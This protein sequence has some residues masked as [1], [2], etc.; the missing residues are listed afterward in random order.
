VAKDGLTSP[1]LFAS[2]ARG[3]VAP[4]YLLYGEEDL[5]VE[6]ALDAILQAALD[7]GDRTFNLD[8]LGAGETDGRDIA[9]RASSFPMAGGRRVVVVRDADKLSVHDCELL[10]AYVGEPSPSTCLILVAAKPDLRKKPFAT[11]KRSGGALECKRLYEDKI[12]SW[13][14]GAVRKGGCRIEPEAAK[15]LAAYVGTSLRE[16]RSE[17]DKLY[18]Y[19]GNRKEITAGDVSALVG[20]SKEYS[21]FELQKVVG[22]RETARA[23]RILEEILGAGGGPPL[24]IATMTNYSLT[25][26]KLHDLQRR[27]VAQ[28]DQAAQARVHPFFIQEY[29]EALGFQ[30]PAACERALLLL[31]DADEQSKSGT[32]DARQVME[33]LI[34]RLCGAEE[35]NIGR[36]PVV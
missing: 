7:G 5:L 21:P 36:A 11:I 13:I 18:I 32:Y 33:S 30:P 15:L 14:A 25:L 20:M 9:A 22:R 34:V 10:A 26:W 3:A 6:E 35:R 19:V 23:M 4:V 8:V 31:A 29:H 17:L 27:G 24:V 12:P 28:K 16:I 1:E 2:L